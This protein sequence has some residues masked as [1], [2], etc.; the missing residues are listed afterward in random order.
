V[1]DL[2]DVPGQVAGEAE[3]IPRD[4]WGRP[5]VVPPAGG[6][7]IG[8][9]RA[10][11]LAGLLEDTYNLSRWQ[12]RMVAIGL[13]D[14]PD[15]VLAVGAHRD[16]KEKLNGIAED[17]MEAAKAH[18]AATTG[19]AIHALTERID[20]GQLLGE[21]PEQYR[22]DLDA[23]ER[24][25]RRF[26]HLAIERFTVVD[27]LKVGGTPDRIVRFEGE[28][29]IFDLKTGSSV[30][31]GAGK[32]AMQLGIYSRA[33]AYNWRTQTREPLPEVNQE[34]GIV[35]HL[36]AGSG[37]CEL[38]WVDIAAGWDAVQLAVQVKAHRA[39]KSWY[40][41]FTMPLADQIAAAAT[42]ADLYAIHRA[43]TAQWTD[44][45]TQLAAA[46]KRV[47]LAGDA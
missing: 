15:L 8:Y 38:K 46:R 19:T 29:Y 12:Q 35:A 43:N 20:R 3:E 23:Y 5:L 13:A 6:K 17:A 41:P 31:F 24:A 34:R 14:R 18:A 40:S 26:E 28:N 4:R 10:T 47:L 25:T 36:P 27:E 42:V 44:E 39:R 2:F 16:N 37:H 7:P 45:L 1:T 30:D 33:V 9:T 21:V 11:H 22:S 32:I